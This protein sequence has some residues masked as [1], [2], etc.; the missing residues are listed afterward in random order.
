MNVRIKET[1][2]IKQLEIID[3]KSGCSW[4]ADL[5]GNHNVG[6]WVDEDGYEGLEITSDDYE[7]WS[8]FCSSYEEADFELYEAKC[9]A[10]DF[11]KAEEIVVQIFNENQCDIEYLPQ[12]MRKAIEAIKACV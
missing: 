4:I 8:D 5:L 2:E 11:N 10:K 3:P 1:K 9:E 7:W 6:E 12:V